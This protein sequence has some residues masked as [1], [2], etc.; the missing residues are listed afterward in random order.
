MQ[1]TDTIIVAG[2]QR[3]RQFRRLKDWEQWYQ[4]NA[5]P[6][7]TRESIVAQAKQLAA[8]EMNVKTVGDFADAHAMNQYMQR[9]QQLVGE[10]TAHVAD[11]NRDAEMHN[12][13]LALSQADID[14]ITDECRNGA[15]TRA[16]A[17][18]DAVRLY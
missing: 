14:G 11:R 3:P 17:E 4:K 8:Q 5:R 6:V 7:I 16:R 10:L 15:A 2:I 1:N 9:V 12:A 13:R 18:S